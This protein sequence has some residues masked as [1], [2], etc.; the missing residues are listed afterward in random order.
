MNLLHRYKTG[1]ILIGQ[2]EMK[3]KMNQMELTKLERQKTNF[4]DENPP[5]PPGAKE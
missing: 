4:Q 5:P 3:E 2:N 1:R